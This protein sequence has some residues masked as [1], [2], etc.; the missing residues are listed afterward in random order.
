MYFPRQGSPK[1]KRD[2]LLTSLFLVSFPMVAMAQGNP[3]S[4]NGCPMFSAN[5][6]FNTPISNLPVNAN[7]GAYVS[8]L[9]AGPAHPD[10]GQQTPGGYVANVVHG[11]SVP[12]AVVNIVWPFTSDTGPFPIPSNAV[13]GNSGDYH[14][15]VLDVDNCMLY[16][17]YN[18]THNSDGSWTVDA[19]SKFNLR[20]DALKPPDW[21]SANA[22]GTAQ[23]PL[24]IR[25]DEVAAGAVNHA[26]SMTGGVT[27]STYVWPASHS[28]SSIAAAPPM[29]TRFRLKANY[30]I[31]AFTPQAKVVAQALKTYGAILTDNGA[32]WHLNGVSDP[33]FDDNDLHMLTQIP[34]SAFE[35]VDE[36]SLEISAGSGDVATVAAATANSIAVEPSYGDGAAQTFTFSYTS[37]SQAQEHFLFNSSLNGNGACYLIY[38]R[39]W[40]QLLIANDQGDGVLASAA[41]GSSTMLASS[42]CSVPV[43]QVSVSTSGSTIELTVPITF[44]P[45][46]RGPKEVFANILDSSYTPGTWQ[47]IGTWTPSGSGVAMSPASGSGVTQTFS[48]AYTSTSQAQ[49]HLI[50]NS[51]LTGNGAC[52]VI[53]DRNWNQLLIANDQGNGVLASTAPGSS[54]T[55]ANDQC[56]VVNSQVAF[57]PSGNTVKLTLTMTFA[58]SFTGP[59][60]VYANILNSSYVPGTWQQIGTW[61][62]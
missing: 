56:S 42:Q 4:F 13:I 16:E 5:H 28:A 52:Y 1:L 20:S 46:F 8:E 47:Q 32:S 54:V 15:I 44:S 11:N 62:P 2:A 14:L 37:S 6:V 19:I 30:D 50:F 48:I 23:L 25:Y 3:P 36:S 31:S 53:Y 24:N 41:P 51:S 9:G 45:S 17:A 40:N 27:G 12:P 33:G 7:S 10:F 22:A 61:T 60:N 57:S 18:T 34:G 35:A 38:D 58:P 55:L 26:I 39:N 21:S 43:S 29:G 59:K 49:E